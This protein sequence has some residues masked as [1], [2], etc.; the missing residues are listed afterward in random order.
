MDKIKQF[1]LSMKTKEFWL[2]FFHSLVWLMVLI[3]VIDIVS[4]WIIQ[5]NLTPGQKVDFIPGFISFT[6]SY[7]LGASFGMGSDGSI[8][9]RILWISISVIMSIALV[10]VYVKNYKKLAKSYKVALALM[11][12]G[13]VGNMIDRCFYWNAIVGFDGVIDWISISFFPPIFNIADSSLVIGAA[14]LLVLFI[15]ELV[16]EGIEKGKRGEYKYSPKELEAQLNNKK[17]DENKG[18]PIGNSTDEESSKEEENH[19]EER[20]NDDNE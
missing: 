16:K 15:I 14:I 19:V 2:Q 7:N 13:A 6:L 1:L 12:A 20:V 4:K 5:N 9:F 18:E 3:F 8:P 17:K 10:F 11:I